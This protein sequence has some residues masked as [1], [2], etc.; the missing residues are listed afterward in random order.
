MSSAAD[1][2]LVALVPT[3]DNPRSV[4]RVVEG[5]RR[6]LP[7]VLVIDDGSGPEGREACAALGERGLAQVVRRP[8]NGGKGAAVKTG[9]AEARA[10]GYTHAFQ[11]D[12]DGQHDLD[13]IPRFVAAAQ[14]HPDALVLSVPVFGDDVPPGR[15]LAR[16]ITQFWVNLETGGRVIHDP[17][18]GFRVYPLAP[19]AALQIGADRMDFDPEVAV[20]LVWSGVPVLNLPL[21]VFYP[22]DR[23]SHFRLLR[24][25]LA[26]SGLH[27]RLCIERVVGGLLLGRRFHR[28]ELPAE[29]GR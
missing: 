11:I 9:F 29:A 19:L 25:N 3:Y 14:A 24:D 20:R 17:M 4:A 2:R 13:A 7:D 1:V 28:R 23:V 12:A 22:P 8:T 26:L 16:S 27:A 18:C 6:H 15:I 21:D 5:I 10:R